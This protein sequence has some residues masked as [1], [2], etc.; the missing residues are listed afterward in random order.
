[1]NW[2]TMA[3]YGDL[4]SVID[5]ADV[6]GHKN[7]YINMLQ[8]VALSNLMMNVNGTHVLDV[9]CGIGRFHD[10]FVHAGSYTGIDTCE[11]MSPPIVASC[12]DIPYDDETFDVI[13]SVWTLQYQK[14]LCEC[15]EEIK[16]V[17]A[18]GGVVYLIEQISPYHHDGVCARWLK[19]YAFEFED[20]LWYKPLLRDNDP[21]VGIVRRGLIPER[22]FRTIVPYHIR[23]TKYL[24]PRVYT[25][26]LMFWEKRL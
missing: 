10:L 6:V 8:H 3:S 14:N 5:P 24:I 19:E 15:V 26:Y 9:G 21:F 23:M 13:L 2:D 4:R 22:L 18:P 1:M 12:D 16:R 17:L 20:T 25:D 11:A 7:R